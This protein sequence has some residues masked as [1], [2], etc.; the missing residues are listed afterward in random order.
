[1]MKFRNLKNGLDK[2]SKSTDE[3]T[4]AVWKV[5]RY[6]YYS[7]DKEYLKMLPGI[8][9]MLLEFGDIKANVTFAE[10]VEG[11][12]VNDQIDLVINSEY[13][14]VYADNLLWLA[15]LK[16]PGTD[17]NKIATAQIKHQMPTDL[18][19]LIG[20]VDD[21]DSTKVC[22]FLRSCSIDVEY[23]EKFYFGTPTSLYVFEDDIEKDTPR[24]R[25]FINRYRNFLKFVDQYE[26]GEIIESNKD[27]I[28]GNEKSKG[29]R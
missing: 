23:L 21:V 10:A 18:L 7:R 15:D 9:K 26:L 1:M 20:H 19:N 27:V 14:D 16:V 29:T 17:V 22:L 25:E 6:I 8:E 24:I 13:F 3:H 5:L 28:S 11:A 4:L 12:S 2:L